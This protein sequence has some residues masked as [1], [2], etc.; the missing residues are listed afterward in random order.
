MQQFPCYPGQSF[1]P[2]VVPPQQLLQPGCLLLASYSDHG[3]ASTVELPL[4]CRLEGSKHLLLSACWTWLKCVQPQ[5]YGPSNPREEIRLHCRRFEHWFPP[6]AK[7]TLLSKWSKGKVQVSTLLTMLEIEPS[8]RAPLGCLCKEFQGSSREPLFL[9]LPCC[10]CLL[11]ASR[12]DKCP[13]PPS[14]AMMNFPFCGF[15]LW[16]LPC[17]LHCVQLQVKAV[18][19]CLKVWMKSVNCL[20]L[21]LQCRAGLWL[22]VKASCREKESQSLL[23]C[24]IQL[25]LCPQ[26]FVFISC[27]C[28]R[29]QHS[30]LF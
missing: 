23:A 28:S 21:L 1:L 4:L 20:L 10:F 17:C 18:G 29:L 8:L 13:S 27:R 22:Q 26:C 3:H 9:F 2:L 14:T 24:D 5:G 30:Q 6:H 15:Q 16:M 12:Q 19:G 7:C 25:F 11:N